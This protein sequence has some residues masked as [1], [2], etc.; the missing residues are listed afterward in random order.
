VTTKRAI[1]S[2]VAGTVLLAASAAAQGGSSGFSLG[3]GGGFAQADQ[4]VGYTVLSTLEF[5][6]PV[7][8]LRP[9]ADVF[10]ANWGRWPN[11]AGVTGNVLL[12]PFATGSVAPYVLIGVGAYLE[13]DSNPK[14]GATLGFGLRLPGALR[15]VVIESQAHVYRLEQPRG[16]VSAISTTQGPIIDA[17]SIKRNRVIWKPL[18]LAIQF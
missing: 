9:R 7:R 4:G 13:E 14:A 11:V 12:T 8:M 2:A 6:S 17:A 16:S 18:G 3:V 1:L 10:Y 5:P 15:S